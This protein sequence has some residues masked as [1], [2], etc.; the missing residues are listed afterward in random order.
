MFANTIA[1]TAEDIIQ[2]CLGRGLV[3]KSESQVKKRPGGRHWHLG[4]PS[5]TGVLEL[6]EVGDE[7]SLKVADN[8]DGGWATALAQELAR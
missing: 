1:R 6:T 7:V 2:D 4:Y 5:R 3:V 8:R